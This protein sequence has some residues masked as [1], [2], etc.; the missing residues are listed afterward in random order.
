[1]TE[2]LWDPWVAR[3]DYIEVMLDRSEEN[4]AAFLLTGIPDAPG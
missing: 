4:V 1:L 3:D 2:Y